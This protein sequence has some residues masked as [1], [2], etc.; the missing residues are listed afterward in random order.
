MI[1]IRYFPTDNRAKFV[2]MIF[3]KRGNCVLALA[4]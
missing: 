1:L 4:L 2:V 3:K